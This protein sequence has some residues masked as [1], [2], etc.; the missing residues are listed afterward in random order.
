M[1]LELNS[2]ELGI[3]AYDLSDIDG[4]R[5]FKMAQ[6]GGRFWSLMWDMDQALRNITKHGSKDYEGQS[7]KSAADLADIIRSVLNEATNGFEE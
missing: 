1:K 7:F 5:N 3:L 2:T 4:K 6:D